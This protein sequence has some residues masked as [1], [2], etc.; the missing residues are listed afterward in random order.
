MSPTIEISEKVKKKLERYKEQEGIKTFSDAVNVLLLS[1]KNYKNLERLLD[2]DYS[3]YL[4]K[5]Y[6]EK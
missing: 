1:F 3:D 2:S 6:K 5:K 4:S